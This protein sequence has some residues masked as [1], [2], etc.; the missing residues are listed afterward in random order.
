M[1][2]EVKLSLILGFAV[3]LAVGVLLSDHL[4]GARL[5]RMEGLDPGRG[6]VPVTA[7][8]PSEDS[9]GLILVDVEGR[10]QP[11]PPRQP[12]TNPRP[13]GVHPVRMANANPAT[14]DT[15]GSTMFDRF[16]QR[17]V[18]AIGQAVDD[19]GNGNVPPGTVQ[20]ATNEPEPVLDGVQPVDRN[21]SLPERQNLAAE[22]TSVP[23]ETAARTYD[24]R[25]GDTLWSIST[26]LLGDGKR[27]KE[28]VELN[29]DRIGAGNALRVGTTLR[30]P[31]SSKHAS[32]D[33]PQTIEPR[34]AVP[35]KNKNGKTIYLVKSGDTLGGIAAKYLGSSSKYDQLL[36]ANTSTLKDED[37]LVVGMELMIPG[38]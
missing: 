6:I 29:R 8:A 33:K 24:V 1:T 5:A 10:P 28:L 23:T 17:A 22:N 25:E 14:T 2:R 3:V 19:L 35:L 31:S 32:A 18:T 11:A 7:N 37:S 9:P 4:S 27:H 34:L 26:R 36:L 16:Q 20:L 15:E 38:R 12:S 30:L 13:S 21:S